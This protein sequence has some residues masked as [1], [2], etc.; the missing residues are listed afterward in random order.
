MDTASYRDFTGTGAQNYEKYFVP[1]IVEPVARGLLVA[2][3]LQEGDRVLDVGCGTGI[4]ARQAATAVGSNGSV[5]GVD[6]APDM[7]A[8]AASLPPTPG[9]EIEWREGDATA[10]PFEDG[11][12]D[13]VLS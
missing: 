5:T 13:V 7:L 8:T 12:F 10:L 4:V 2:A 1:V 11:A 3:V 9:P 6:V